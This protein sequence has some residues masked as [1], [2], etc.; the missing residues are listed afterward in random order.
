MKEDGVG[1]FDVGRRVAAHTIEKESLHK[2]I[3]LSFESRVASF[4]EL[5]DA[6]VCIV[7]G[8]VCILEMGFQ[9]ISYETFEPILLTII[10]WI[11]ELR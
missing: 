3:R 1:E 2:K 11:V 5:I 4:L 9:K 8:D 7:K 6:E 10:E